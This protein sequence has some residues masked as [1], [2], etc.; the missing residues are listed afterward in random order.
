MR[1]RPTPLIA[2][3]AVAALAAS[4]CVSDA[5]TPGNR[6]GEALFPATTIAPGDI[7]DGPSP[8]DPIITV[9]SGDPALVTGGNAR[10]RI[11]NVDN[12]TT[13]RLNGDDVTAAFVTTARGAREGVVSGL[14]LGANSLAVTANGITFTENLTNYPRR[15]PVFSG[16]QSQP[17]ICTTE[18]H[19]LGP[20]ADDFCG[21]PT[22]VFWTYVDAEGN[23]QRLEGP[24][25]SVSP[26]TVELGGAPV[27]FFIRNEVGT[28]NRSVYWLHSVDPQPAVG[29]INQAWS[30]TDS[31]NRRLV[32]NYGPGCGATYSQGTPSVDGGGDPALGGPVDVELLRQGYA[33]ANSTFTTFAT[34]CNDVLSAETT[35]MVKERF[36]EG[37]GVP[38]LTIATGGSGGAMQGLLVAQNQP[39]LLDGVVASLP[40]PDM[41]TVLP[42]VI[43]CELLGTFYQ[44]DAGQPLG[45][46]QRA[47]INGHL[48]SGTCPLWTQVLGPTFSPWQGCDP[49]LAD[50][51]FIPGFNPTG[52]RCTPWD[53]ASHLYSAPDAEGHPEAPYDNVGVQYGLQ[54]FQDR[55]IGVG[56]FLAL[57]ETIGGRDADGLPQAP[58]SSAR[59][60]QIERLYREGRVNQGGGD[61]RRIPIVLI[62]PYTDP[63]GDIHDRW[64]VFT[65][66]DRI[67][68]GASTPPPNVALWTMETPLT[69]PLALTDYFASA[70]GAELAVLSRQAVEAVDAWASAAAA[71]VDGE[72]ANLTLDESRPEVAADRC[73]LADGET[74]TGPDVN[75]PGGPCDLPFAG[76]P[77][78][79]AGADT[80]SLVL[81]C[82]LREIDPADYPVEL[83]PAARRRLERVFPKGVCDFDRPGQGQAR[84]DD[85]SAEG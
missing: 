51:V 25:D 14:A 4:A 1:I 24:P 17:L 75:A 48:T 20:P 73:I 32:V 10:V 11:E 15:G 8:D 38:D 52:I 61:L 56:Q 34:H 37:Y 23:L 3:V 82:T 18:Q 64:R 70:G 19:G 81:Q 85:P 69:S 50:D 5:A 28:I 22:Q 77:R 71:E 74:T 65:I 76:D 7:V 42:G 9:V 39:G 44:S 27:D 83:S 57:N 80:E 47:A 31:W 78:T 2:V 54:A 45:A 79:V 60:G 84:L 26:A 13:V 59:T 21:A 46:E 35:M 16:P 41:V 36:I 68:G 63:A 33:V 30:G 40:F 12:D 66:R 29:T 53:A 43:D 6:A 58:R 62:N 55:V 49:S 67:G 72:S